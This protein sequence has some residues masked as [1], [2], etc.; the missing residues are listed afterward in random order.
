MESV[1]VILPCLNEAA[2]LP[3]VIGT[4]PTGYGVLVID[5]GSDDGSAGIAR[6]LGARV[7][8]CPQRGYGAA[9]QAGL[10]AADADLVVVMDAD[11]SLDGRQLPWLV[12]LVRDDA[13]DLAIG[14][15]RPAGRGAWP[16]WLRLAN[17]ELARELSVRTKRRIRD[18]GPMRAARREALLGLGLRDQRSGYPAETLIAAAAA[19]WRIGQVEVDYHPRIGASKVTGTP[20]GAL[21][22][23]RDLRAVLASR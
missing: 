19:G 4:I 17:A 15:R 5:N 6:G 21:R 10:L 13:V 14:I 20:I 18:L 8:H 9:C 1:Q 23:A 3:T 2:A 22:A 16:W 12:N 11:G 7:V